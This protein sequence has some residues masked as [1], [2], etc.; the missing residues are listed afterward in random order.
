MRCNENEIVVGYIVGSENRDNESLLVPIAVSSLI[1]FTVGVQR[2]YDCIPKKILSKMVS[3]SSSLS[4]ADKFI[5]T[6]LSTARMLQ[7]ES[8]RDRFAV[9][10]G[11]NV[12]NKEYLSLKKFFKCIG[13][14]AA[15]LDEIRGRG[16]DSCII[17]EVSDAPKTPIP[18]SIVPSPKPR[19]PWVYTDII[20][21]SDP[22]LESFKTD[23]KRILSIEFLYDVCSVFPIFIG[24]DY[25]WLSLARQFEIAIYNYYGGANQMY[26]EKIQDLVGAMAGRLKPGAL[27]FDIIDGKFS[28]PEEVIE[29]PRKVLDR[30][31]EGLPSDHR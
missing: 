15:Y 8:K 31:F 18:T 19:P 26:W 28:T 2:Q 20:S 27:I 30:S 14:K 17:E 22:R 7:I 13:T 24:P 5:I 9:L 25:N 29:L 16:K 6:N 1:S 12:R 11:K 21:N 23:R 4:V 3:S 10:H